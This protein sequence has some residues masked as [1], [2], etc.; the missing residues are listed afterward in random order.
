[1][2]AVED[3]GFALMSDAS[4]R[5]REGK[6]GRGWLA[7]RAGT[8]DLLAYEAAPST[9]REGPGDVNFEEVVALRAALSFAVGVAMGWDWETWEVTGEVL[10]E[11][12][13]DEVRALVDALRV[14]ALSRVG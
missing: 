8:G 2:E 12:E 7:L 9:L 1:M 6:I 11:G 14:D 5:E 4:I 10:R 3:T 13:V